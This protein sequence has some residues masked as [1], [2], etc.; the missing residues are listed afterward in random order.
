M[1]YRVAG[2]ALI[3]LATIGIVLPLL[4]TTPLVLL[5]AWCFAK[6]SPRLHQ[7]LLNHALFGPIISQWEQNRCVG[8]KTKMIALLSMA[9][10]G[11]LPVLIFVQMLAVK[12]IALSL[13]AVGAVV[14]LR[15]PVCS[16]C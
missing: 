9:V 1:I 15:L 11:A 7:W 2:I 16:Q 13:M 3:V 10:F 5:A 14:V 4:P 12:I 8:R 6:S